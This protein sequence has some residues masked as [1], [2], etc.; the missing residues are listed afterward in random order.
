MDQLHGHPS[1]AT[2]DKKK[3]KS[4][5]KNKKSK[6]DLSLNYIVKEIHDTINI[7]DKRH[8]RQLLKQ[9]RSTLDKSSKLK[10]SKFEAKPPLAGPQAHPNRPDD[11][12]NGPNLSMLHAAP[13]AGMLNHVQ[14]STTGL[15]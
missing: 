14:L 12:E 1:A 6:K 15:L 2:L 8:M 4:K 7:E 13:N 11:T 3:S 10:V 9:R 5:G